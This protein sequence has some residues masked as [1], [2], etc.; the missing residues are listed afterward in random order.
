M[1]SAFTDTKLRIIVIAVVAIGIMLQVFGTDIIFDGIIKM[2]IGLF[3]GLTTVA[4]VI[5]M[6]CTIMVGIIIYIFVGI[7]LMIFG[8]VCN[9]F[10]DGL[11]ND[12]IS[13]EEVF[14]MITTHWGITFGIIILMIIGFFW[15]EVYRI[16]HSKSLSG[17]DLAMLNP[18]EESSITI[19]FEIKKNR[20]Q[21]LENARNIIRTM[22]KKPKSLVNR[23]I[24]KDKNKYK[25]IFQD[26][27]KRTKET[28]EK[29]VSLTVEEKEFKS[30]D[31]YVLLKNPFIG[32]FCTEVDDTNIRL[33]N[34]TVTNRSYLI[35]NHAYFDGWSLM[36]MAI[37]FF[38]DENSVKYNLPLPKL[39]YYPIVFEYMLFK[40]LFQLISMKK[41]QFAFPPDRPIFKTHK[42]IHAKINHSDVDCKHH[43]MTTYVHTIIRT[44]FDSY[45]GRD[46]YNVMILTAIDNPTKINNVSFIAFTSERTDTIDITAKK[47][48]SRKEQALTTYFYINSLFR[49]LTSGNENENT[50]DICISSVPFF[51]KNDNIESIGVVIPYL[52]KP[53]YIFNSKIGD[54]TTSSIHFGVKGLDT[55]V[56]V[57]TLKT[58][59][60]TVHEITVL[61]DDEQ[62]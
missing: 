11:C 60:A 33:L 30:K 19:M 32:E 22:L 57:E 48:K 45:P 21:V 17:L 53:I 50:L 58:N 41:A 51:K 44:F 29:I 23:R 54:I 36:K 25:M 56:F 1:I 34:D 26:E 39:I 59:K 31:N 40:M 43:Y 46:H 9:T 27:T 37:E 42:V 6:I 28:E 14:N 16:N 10:F 5:L 18:I 13:F 12:S 62:D 4:L 47:I 61:P 52:S 15:F 24:I 55:E 49:K 8:S 3:M 20:V 2:S 35:T 7:P 38:S